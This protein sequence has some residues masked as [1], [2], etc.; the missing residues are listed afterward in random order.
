[1]AEPKTR[2]TDGDVEA[3]LSSVPEPAQS[4]CRALVTMMSS[5]TGAAPVMWGSSIVGFGSVHYRY[6][7]GREG[8]WFRVGFSPRKRALTVYLMDG[9]DRHSHQLERLGEHSVGKGCLYIKRLDDVDE[10]VLVEIVNDSASY[11]G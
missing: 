11:R 5:A 7:S 10:D 9:V 6:A 3:F 8:D 4:D 1:M 2:P